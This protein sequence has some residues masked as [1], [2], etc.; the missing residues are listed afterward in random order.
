MNSTSHKNQKAAIFVSV[1]QSKV[2]FIQ[3]AF[4]GDVILFTS[5]LES[6]QESH[7]NSKVDVL[8]RKGN[9]ILLVNHP[10]VDQLFI[11]DKQYGKY[12][13]LLKLSKQIRSNNYDFV[14]NFQRF[15]AS[16]FL[17][18]RSR[19]KESRGY[20]KNPLSRF[21]SKKYPHKIGNGEHEIERNF[22]LIED[23]V[24]SDHPRQPRLYPSQSDFESIEKYQAEPYV[25]MAPT[26]VW[27]TKQLPIKK[28]E[29]L[30][31]KIPSNY[32]IYLIGAPGDNETCDSLVKSSKNKQI[33]NLC[34]ELNLIQS[35]A[36]ISKAR[37]NYV[38]DSAP[39]HLA[40]AMEAPV[41]SFFCSTIPD[42]G[43]GPLSS[44]SH[45]LE[46]DSK[47]EC[48]PCGL[49]GFKEC[50]KGHFNCGNQIDIKTNL[51]E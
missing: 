36:L 38:N 39:Q 13:N 4:I 51:D 37:M 48:R 23:L 29:E 31:D 14:V 2:L 24:N 43:F 50:P 44:E 15:F 47:L 3:T 1:E 42:F 32:N 19:S 21:F 11:W 41:T 26:S 18:I 28:W 5:I 10:I 9:E 16:G 45:I 6:W 22:A 35:A 7:P 25:V 40:S 34:G 27:F 33:H 8:V 20:A 46:V 17:T 49:H 30:I 12:K